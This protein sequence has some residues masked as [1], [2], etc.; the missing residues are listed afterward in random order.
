M[1]KVAVTSST[2]NIRKQPNA[3]SPSAG[4]YKQGDVVQIIARVDRRYLRDGRFHWLLTDKGWIAEQF[5]EPV[6]AYSGTAV[7][8]TP[9]MHAPGSDW[10]WQLAEVQTFMRE[11]NLPVKFLSI[12][13]SPDYWQAFHKPAF[14]LVR[15]YWK[16]DG[17]HWTPEKMWNAVKQ[18]TLRFYNQGARKFELHNEPNLPD[19][20]MGYVWQNGN[21]F[22]RWLAQ[23]AQLIKADAPETELYYPG[24]SP[25]VP[26]TNQFEFTDAAWPHVADL[27]HGICQHAY[28]GTTNNVSKAVN[29]IIDQVTGFQKRYA[30]E[31]PLVISECSVNRAA[32]ANYKAQVYRNIE[33]ELA[34]M[35]GI[36]ALVYFISHW[37]A[38]PEQA[39]HQEA[40]MGT[41][42]LSQYKRLA[43]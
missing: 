16:P 40:W 33:Q 38:P 31:R 9:A 28:T 30:L 12:G 15:I 8:F 7:T 36:E 41:D 26:W 37:E 23:L 25:G 24:L 2:L 22:G 20:G 5:T 17:K 29:D 39:A 13:F 27:M 3:D 11:V 42:L 21:E 19:E 4:Q 1:P 10:M 18:D 32:P 6:L 35:P 34:N 14:H 43:R